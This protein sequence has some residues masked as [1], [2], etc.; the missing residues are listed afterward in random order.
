VGNG[1]RLFADGTV[2]AGFKLLD[3][4]T[5][6]TGVVMATYEPAGAV[7]RGSFEFDEPTSAEVERRQK[8]AAEDSAGVRTASA[9]RSTA[10]DARSTGGFA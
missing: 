3:A 8:L 7:P 4:T 9:P 1:K 10:A 2:P 5:S 6:T